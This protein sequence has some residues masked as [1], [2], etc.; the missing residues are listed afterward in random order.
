MQSIMAQLVALLDTHPAQ[1]MAA[2]QAH[3]CRASQLDDVQLP[4]SSLE[5]LLQ[6]V[7][8]WPAPRLQ[9]AA[10]QMQSLAAPT[11]QASGFIY[12]EVAAAI[13][14]AADVE[15]AVGSGQLPLSVLDTLRDLACL[16]AAPGAAAGAAT[17]A[18]H[19]G[20]LTAPDG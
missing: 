16:A 3:A 8:A 14:A 13:I 12:A 4:A 19:E 1:L 6:A 15:V 10:H 2:F 18:M 20:L 9:F 5:A 7:T 11:A 17:L